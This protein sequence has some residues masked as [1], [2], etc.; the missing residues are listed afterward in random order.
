MN[1]IHR[2][3]GNELT[4]LQN[5]VTFFPQLC[6]DIGAARQSVYLET[7]IFA[8]D[9]TG[10]LVAEALR[11]A[12]ER[13]VAVRVMLDGFGSAELPGAF[14]DDL[15]KVGVEVQW[16]RREI[17]PFTLR[18]SRM[19]R[20]RRMHRKLA[21]IDGKVAYVGGINI[22]HDIP[23]DLNFNAPRL[24]Y[25]VRIQGE[26]V[27]EVEAAMQHL[28]E[29]V[30]WAAFRKRVKEKGWRLYRQK[31]HPDSN[32]QLLVRDNVRHRRDIERAYL[33]GI[34]GAKHE[35]IIANAYFLPGRMIIRALVH[36]ARR[37]VRVVVVLQ[38]K[39]EYRLQHYATL[40]LYGRLLA[41][42]VE[43]YEYHASYLH[44]KVAVVDGE[45]ATVGSFNI[46][47]FSLLLAREANL[48]V[49]DK[50][51]AG[52]LRASLLASIQ[53]DGRRVELARS[54]LLTR[55]FAR[56]SYGLIRFVIGILG[57]TKSH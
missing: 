22:I 25:A 6:A 23:A 42:G 32:V 3:S 2:I 18:R 27:G 56:M 1:R 53:C 44:A 19:R 43:I 40:A 24:D 51:F 5:G 38:G 52:D 30:S 10:Q 46:D 34:V 48:V 13:G 7:Y 28:W 20:L 37:G 54:N 21:V 9:E 49:R 17:S 29:M 33:K 45:W 47:P 35:V 39:V 55:F 31:P 36:A 57:I 4:L 11:H 12:A 8:A 14:V 26:L 16:F 50:D 41:A 15:R